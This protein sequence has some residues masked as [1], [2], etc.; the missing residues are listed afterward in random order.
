MSAKMASVRVK[1]PSLMSRRM[2]VMRHAYKLLLAATLFSEGAHAQ[3]QAIEIAREA[4]SWGT[5]FLSQ[6]PGTVGLIAR[7]GCEKS[8]LEPLEPVQLRGKRIYLVKN[9]AVY[10][11]LTADCLLIIVNHRTVDESVES[12]PSYL[13]I[14]VIGFY[15]NNQDRS[16]IMR[17][18]GAFTRDGVSLTPLPGKPVYSEQLS[19]DRFNE[20]H[21]SPNGAVADK[22]LSELDEK[23]GTRWHGVPAD[24]TDNSWSDRH[25]FHENEV[26]DNQ[27]QLKYKVLDNRLIRFK[28]YSLS[29]G[30]KEGPLPFT[31]GKNGARASVVRV[32]SPSNPDIDRSFTIIHET[33]PR[34]A[35]EIANIRIL[36]SW[37][38]F[39][40]FR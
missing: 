34:R 1:M 24:G 35:Q 13:G 9:G 8:T 14:Q 19:I 10:F 27:I 26:Y 6:P 38:N 11:G 23:I 2:N 39:W 16:M 17:R 37:F 40:P 12:S 28:P 3:T 36:A 18:K 31:F 25:W 33:D 21:K 32:F 29:K 20:L 15:E 30:P 5:D 4:Q 22:A 7:N